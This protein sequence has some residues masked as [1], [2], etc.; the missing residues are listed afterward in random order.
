MVS[1]IAKGLHIVLNVLS[2]LLNGQQSHLQLVS[3]SNYIQQLFL[4][5]FLKNAKQ[6]CWKPSALAL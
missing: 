1:L 6:L 5:L 3:L 4:D 2:L